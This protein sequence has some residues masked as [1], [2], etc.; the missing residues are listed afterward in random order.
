MS[1]ESADRLSEKKQNPSVAARAGGS[2]FGLVQQNGK[3]FSQEPCS[4]MVPAF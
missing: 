4:R 1:R 3:M 2:Y